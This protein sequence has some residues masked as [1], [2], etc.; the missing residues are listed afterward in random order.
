MVLVVEKSQTG[1]RG[2]GSKLGRL[3]RTDLS[4]T[5]RAW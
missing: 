3:H 4:D 5:S 2:R 1:L